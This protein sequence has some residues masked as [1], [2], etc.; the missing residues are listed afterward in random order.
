MRSSGFSEVILCLD[1]KPGLREHHGTNL[2]PA[3]LGLLKAHLSISSPVCLLL[4]FALLGY[5]LPTHPCTGSGKSKGRGKE[6]NFMTW[7]NT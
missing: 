7:N 1:Q 2:S 3:A 5:T 6:S 4:I